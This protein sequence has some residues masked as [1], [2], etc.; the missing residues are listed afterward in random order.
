MNK[1]ENIKIF[2]EKLGIE[3][4]A[5]VS[6]IKNGLLEF[7]KKGKKYFVCEEWYQDYLDSFTFDGFLLH[8]F[9]KK[10]EKAGV[11]KIKSAVNSKMSVRDNKKIIKDIEEEITGTWSKEYDVIYQ[12]FLAS[13][14]H[15]LNKLVSLHKS[16]IPAQSSIITSQRKIFSSRVSIYFL[17]FVIALNLSFYLLTLAPDRTIKVVDVINSSFVYS[18]RISRQLADR[19]VSYKAVVFSSLDNR[20][21]MKLANDSNFK[22]EYVRENSDSFDATGRTVQLKDLFVKMPGAVE[23]AGIE[24]DPL[25]AKNNF[26][27]KFKSEAVIYAQK[28][29]NRQKDI[30][31]KLNSGLK[32]FFK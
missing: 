5:L 13:H 25:K 2:A 28:I 15:E 17:V 26:F 18:D 27:E 12:D 20:Q 6:L 16:G 14:A 11:K 7:E 10:N 23:V 3:Q 19:I 8:E 30:S 9:V 22:S 24:Y 21:V 4:E 32:N 29:M 31:S 1:L